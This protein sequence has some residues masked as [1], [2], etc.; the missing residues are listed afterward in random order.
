MRS[1]AQRIT[2]PAIEP[3]SVE[4]L[5]LHLRLD[6]TETDELLTLYLSAARAT[7]ER[8]LRR[9]LITATWEWS[10]EAFQACIALPYPPLQSVDHILYLDTQSVPQFLAPSVY[11]VN[12]AS[13]PGSVT[14]A[15][16]QTFPSLA[17][18][19]SGQEVRIQYQAGYGDTAGTIPAP[20]RS[21]ILLLTADLYENPTAQVEM[22][23]Q[24]NRTL[25]F[26]LSMYRIIEMA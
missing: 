9:Q 4:T 16:N 20:I 10:A 8:Y 23:L 26:L 6:T 21:A 14:L 18:S 12:T 3:V 25:C 13:T 1:A 19:Q 24:E 5:R 22:R 15:S 11:L 2:E 17:N 7:V